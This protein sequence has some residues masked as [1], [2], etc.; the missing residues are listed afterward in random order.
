M[1]YLQGWFE[2]NFLENLYDW[3]CKTSS[4]LQGNIFQRKF[5]NK[6]PHGKWITCNHG[7]CT[8]MLTAPP[9]I[10]KMKINC[11]FGRSST[12]CMYRTVFALT[13]GER[14]RQSRLPFFPSFFSLSRC[15]HTLFSF[16]PLF[17]LIFLF[18]LRMS[19][20]TQSITIDCHLWW[21]RHY[22]RTGPE[23]YAHT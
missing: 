12:I 5:Q 3:N 13:P 7:D 9:Q 16:S 21:A 10:P 11:L 23:M 6:N 15:G 20:F 2:N 14:S 18:H 22:P 19:E 8:Y 1:R 4:C 17:P